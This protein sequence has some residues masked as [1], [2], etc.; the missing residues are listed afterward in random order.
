M[1]NVV[2]PVDYPLSVL[3]VEDQEII[4][5]NIR[6]QLEDDGFRV[7]TAASA[8]EACA[9]ID[10]HAG[11]IGAAF[12]DVDLGCGEDGFCVARYAR[13]AAPDMRIVYT[14]GGVRSGVVEE[15]VTDS[16]FVAKPYLPSE[17]G[18]L[19]CAMLRLRPN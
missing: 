8:R 16:L 3:V 13:A 4:L 17:I 5:E 6:Q 10:S 7:V 9:H 1:L 14:S 12:L 19:L 11:Q 18:V 15:R 2:K